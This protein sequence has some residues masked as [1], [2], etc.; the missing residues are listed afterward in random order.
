MQVMRLGV[1]PLTYFRRPP[2]PLPECRLIST[3]RRGL[4]GVPDGF[5]FLTIGLPGFRKGWDVLADAMELAFG[6]SRK[7]AL[8][9]GLTHAPGAWKEKVYKQFARY[10]VPIW[11]LE[12]S[13]DEHQLAKI[14]SSVGAYVSASLGE[15]FNL[16]AIEA[17]SCGTPV[18]VPSNTCHPELFRECLM[19]PTDGEKVYPEGD[20]ISDWYKGMLFSRFGKKSIRI[21]SGILETVREGGST[22]TAAQRALTRRIRTTLTWD[23]AAAAATTRLLEVQP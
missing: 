20:W 5:T 11:T 16:P 18:V 15:G 2:E 13:F 22:V 8:V 23:E 19:F 17:G 1:D 9:I 4:R 7:V 10:K 3:S 6:G 21:L 12:G 14:Y